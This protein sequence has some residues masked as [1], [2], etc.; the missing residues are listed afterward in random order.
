MRKKISSPLP[1]LPVKP[2]PQETAFLS[3]HYWHIAVLLVVLLSIIMSYRINRPFSGIHSWDEACTAWVARAHVNYGLGYTKGLATREVGNPPSPVPIHY[4][5]HPHLTALVDAGWMLIFGQHERTLRLEKIAVAIITLLL[6]LQL[7]RRWLTD[8]TALLA[9]L[10]FVLCPLTGYFGVGGWVLPISLWCLW[11]YLQ[12]ISPAQLPRRVRTRLLVELALA[13][14]L[15]NQFSWPG[16]FYA[17][18]FP[19]HYLLSR[20]FPRKKPSWP[21]LAVVIV[22]PLASFG[23]NMLIM[24]WGYH[25]QFEKIFSLFQWRSAKG[26]VREFTWSAWLATFGRHLRTN[27][28]LPVLAALIFYWIYQLISR[29]ARWFG[30][31]TSLSPAASAGDIPPLWFFLLPAVLFILTFRGL[32][33]EHQYWLSP[34]LLFVVIFAAAGVF[35]LTNLLK[36]I[37]PAAISHLVTSALIITMFVFSLLGLRDYHSER[38]MPRRMLQLFQKLNRQIAPAQALLSF[39]DYISQQHEAKGRFYRPEFAW[40]LD[41]PIIAA[42]SL[43]DIR[44]AAATGRFPYYYIPDAQPPCSL[45]PKEMLALRSL[46]DEQLIELMPSPDSQPTHSALA[47]AINWELTQRKRQTLIPRLKTLYPYEYFREDPANINSMGNLP[48]YIF[49]L[50]HPLTSP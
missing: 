50:S 29:A 46:S 45:P 37:A 39:N 13:L 21:L 30:R 34:F 42:R 48:G 24:L 17:W 16:F 36:K 4:L 3:R 18:V 12:L 15:L 33:W 2:S 7:I 40:Y 31:T 32:L 27:F 49:D 47:Y 14:F 41:R 20:L 8:Q 28:T 35:L 10:L 26:E 11:R 22:M 43:S 23:L 25:W 19:A 5:S 1:S 9:G 6:F 44:R 38:W